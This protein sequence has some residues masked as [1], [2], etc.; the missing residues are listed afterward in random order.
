MAATAPYGFK[1]KQRIISFRGGTYD[2]FDES[3]DQ[4]LFVAKRKVFTLRPTITIEN[5]QGQ[6]VAQV[7]GNFF[8]GTKWAITQGVN[9]VGMVKFPLIRI[10]GIKFEVELA[11]KRYHASDVMGWSFVAR[12]ES[13]R[14]GFLLDKKIFRIKDTYKIEVYPPLEPVLALAASLA[15]DI[16]FYQGNR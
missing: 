4:Q 5:L 2:I 13:N 9:L 16:K 14:I 11:G 15:I 10:C 8:I 6:E 3:T 7:K 12:D 1:I